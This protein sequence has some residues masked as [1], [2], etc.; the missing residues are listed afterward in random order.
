MRLFRVVRHS[1][2]VLLNVNRRKWNNYSYTYTSH[3]TNF[4]KHILG[5]K[6]KN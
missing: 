6:G 2:C 5:Y 1:E 4:L 3:L